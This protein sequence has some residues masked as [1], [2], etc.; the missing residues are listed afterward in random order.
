MIENFKSI[1]T[2]YTKKSSFYK[3]KKNIN[4]YD[5]ISFEL[6][7]ISNIIK[8]KLDL[9]DISLIIEIIN[10]IKNLIK[11]FYNNQEKKIL[12]KYEPILLKNENKIREIIKNEFILKNHNILLENKIKALQ[13]KQQEYEK[14][15]K[16]TNVIYEN[17]EF[18]FT[19]RKENEILIL[20][21]ENSNLKK[22]ILKYEK[23]YKNQMNKI[24][25]LENSKT[26][27]ENKL[28]TMTK[29]KISNPIHSYS[30]SRYHTYLYDMNY[31]NNISNIIL[32]KNKKLEYL[33]TSLNN[34]KSNIFQ[35]TFSENKSPKKLTLTIS[36]FPTSQNELC[37]SD[38]QKRFNSEFSSI[39]YD[40]FNYNEFSL[41][42]RVS[43]I[44]RA[45]ENFSNKNKRINSDLNFSPN[46]SR[47][48]SSKK[49]NRNK[50]QNI[51]VNNSSLVNNFLI[52]KN[53]NNNINFNIKEKAGF[54]RNNSKTIFNKNVESK[55]S[56]KNS[57]RESLK[58][59]HKKFKK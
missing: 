11:D 40:N 35:S 6:D 55:I 45:V 58:L 2:S 12:E 17:G 10:K 20:K 46:F 49:I 18:I 27:L 30:N 29:N 13:M 48:K 50:V 33:S 14:L 19:D 42:N 47:K 54:N 16:L 7:R 9:T 8:L 36:Y 51:Y 4:Y 5:E 59:P 34:S 43:P 23:E 57:N 37:F 15:K 28:K 22:E 52:Y 3:L 41:K 24:L 38:R 44:R 53:A 31:S 32:N 25:E 1:E 21:A 26:K 56:K 39:D